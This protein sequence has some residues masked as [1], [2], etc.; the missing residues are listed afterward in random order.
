MMPWFEWSLV[1]QEDPGSITALA[2]F[3]QVQG[4]KKTGYLPILNLVTAEID[5]NKMLAIAVQPEVA[6]DF[7]KKSQLRLS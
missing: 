6:M 1:E 4:V 3:V 2:N 7:S 5:W